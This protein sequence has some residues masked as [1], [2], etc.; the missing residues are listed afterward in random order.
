GDETDTKLPFYAGFGVEELLIVDRDTAA[1]GLLRLAAGAF[2]AVPA[3][4]EGW[5][6]CSLGVSFRPSADNVLDV[7]LPG[8]GIDRC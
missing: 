2:T 6:T 8:G 5:V 1:V 3:D 4:D 7:R